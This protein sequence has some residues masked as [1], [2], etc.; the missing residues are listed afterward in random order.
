MHSTA[1]SAATRG[2]LAG[3][4]LSIG[5]CRDL[6]GA[7]A[8]F[9]CCHFSK[10]AAMSQARSLITGILASGPI[11]SRPSS[12]TFEMWVRQVQR[13]RPFTVM[14]QLPHMPTRQAKR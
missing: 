10:N 4:I 5:S 14:A 11:S 2:A 8:P 3:A 6:L 1:A 7:K 9:A 13:G 12:T